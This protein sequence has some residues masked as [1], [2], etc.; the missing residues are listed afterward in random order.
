MKDDTAMLGDFG[1]AQ[2]SVQ[3]NLDTFAG[4][5]FYLAPEFLE[6]KRNYTNKV[7]RHVLL[8]NGL[9]RVSFY[10]GFLIRVEM[11]KQ[12]AKPSYA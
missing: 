11:A 3:G 12:C 8:R 7:G 5:P 2:H 10:M 1:T 4:T 6:E 9:T